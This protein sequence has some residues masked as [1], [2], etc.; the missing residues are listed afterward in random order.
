MVFT[1]TPSFATSS[2]S[3][4]LKPWMPA[5]AAVVHAVHHLLGHVE[6]GVEVGAHHRVPVGLGHLL[7]RHVARDAGVVHQDVDRADLALDDV[8]LLGARVVVDHV[9]GKGV[10]AVT[11]A[12]HLLSLI[13]ISEPTRLLSISYA[14]FCL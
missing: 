13:H 2:A 12:L 4:L 11:A 6:A 1:V 8:A 7:E 14:V 9:D 10:E 3:A 5:S